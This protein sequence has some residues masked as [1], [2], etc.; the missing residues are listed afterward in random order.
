MIRA[1]KKNTDGCSSSCGSCPFS[2]EKR[3]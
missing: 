1:R 2:C 3:H